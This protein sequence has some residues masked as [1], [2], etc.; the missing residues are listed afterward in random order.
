MK[1]NQIHVPQS[2]EN[3]FNASPIDSFVF[4][5]LLFHSSLI[6]KFRPA[7]KMIVNKRFSQYRDNNHIS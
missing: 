3:V 4:T 7:I 6:T 1:K 2:L 5:W